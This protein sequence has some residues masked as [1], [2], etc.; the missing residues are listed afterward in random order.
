MNQGFHFPTLEYLK[1]GNIFSSSLDDFNFKMFP[2]I[3]DCKI[4]VVIWQGHNCL[5]ASEALFEKIFGL[6]EDGFGEMINWI[7]DNYENFKC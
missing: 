1:F 4:S 3:D 5:D 6:S 2:D 7:K